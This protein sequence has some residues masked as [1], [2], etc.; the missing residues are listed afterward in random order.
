MTR[1]TVNL[2][3]ARVASR[4]NRAKK[5]VKILREKLENQE[6][7]EV[8]ISSEVNQEIWSRGA[9]KPPAKITVDVKA[10]EEGL[11]A[12]SAEQPTTE[13]STTE[14]STSSGSVDYE[15]V[16]EGTVAEVKEEVKEEDL[17]PEKVLEAEKEKK[18]RKTLKQFLQ[19]LI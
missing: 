4:K 10:T 8:T 11:K 17:D 3:R 19:D 1:K 2:S 18:D 7:E 14:S 12:F 9:K 16:V 13:K 5:A 6:D 15:D